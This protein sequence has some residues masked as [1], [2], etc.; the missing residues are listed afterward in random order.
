MVKAGGA[1]AEKAAAL[2]GKI[3]VANA[4]QAYQ[5]F[6][7]ELSAPRYQELASEGARKQ[8]PLWASTSTKNP[9]YPDVLYVDELIGADTVN[10]LPPKTLEA[11]KDHGV[12]KLTIEGEL[13]EANQA[14][15][16]LSGLGLSLDQATAEL[17]DEGVAAFSKSI[18]ALLDTIEE[19]RAAY[20]A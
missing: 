20:V 8:R 18:H 17:E 10:T 15:V 4:K 1:D 11:F 12:A 16:D 9:D 14:I 5:L 2:K 3:A 6:L 13:D 7:E 19:R